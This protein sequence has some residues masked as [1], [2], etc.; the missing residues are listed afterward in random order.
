MTRINTI[1]P[2]DLLDQHLFIEFRE[3]TRIATLA[4]PLP[5]YGEYVLGTGHMKFFYNKG[6]HLAKRLVAL[7]EE[8]DRRKLWNYT[9]KEYRPHSPSLH[10]DWTPDR[11]AHLANL[12]RLNSKVLE[13]PDFYKFHGKPASLDHYASLMTHERY[14][15]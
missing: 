1:D 10:T 3:I 6:A 15:I 5:H 12:V 2:S 7:Q 13:R 8:M 4:R 14:N 11:K 9:P